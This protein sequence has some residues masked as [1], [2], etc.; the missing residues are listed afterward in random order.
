MPSR[1]TALVGQVAQEAADELVARAPERRASL[2]DGDE[3]ALA[4]GHV[5]QA[6]LLFQVVDPSESIR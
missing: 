3:Q 2:G 1:A 4:G 6:A 5:G